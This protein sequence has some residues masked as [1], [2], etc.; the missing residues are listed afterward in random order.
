MIYSLGDKVEAI[1]AIISP[2]NEDSPA[3]VCADRGDVLEVRRLESDFWPLYVAHPE[4]EP[5]AMFG[6]QLKEV[7][8]APLKAR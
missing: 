7:R 6:V 2:A 5:D 1:R 4:R 8:P 3:Y